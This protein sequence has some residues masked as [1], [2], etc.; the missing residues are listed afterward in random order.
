MDFWRRLWDGKKWFAAAPF[1][2]LLSG[3]RLWIVA[4]ALLLLGVALIVAVCWLACRDNTDEVETPILS[5]RRKSS[6]RPRGE[7][8]RG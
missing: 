8:R 6:N 2:P 4:V 3:D 5:W 7:E 1:T